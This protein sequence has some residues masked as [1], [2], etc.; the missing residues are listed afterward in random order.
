VGVVIGYGGL[1]QLMFRGFASGYRAQ[2]MTATIL[3]LLLGLVL[4]LVLSLVG[5]IVT[6]WARTRVAR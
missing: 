2:I 3:C 5:R 1:G 4:D 6:P